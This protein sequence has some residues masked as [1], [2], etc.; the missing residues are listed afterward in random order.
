MSHSHECDTFFIGMRHIFYRNATPYL[1]EKHYFCTM[2]NIF[3]TLTADREFSLILGSAVILLGILFA[4][5]AIREYKMY[6]EDNYKARPSLADFFKQEQFYLYLWLVFLF[7][8]S[9]IRFFA[10]LN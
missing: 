7:M 2:E 6:L 1:L 8:V 10:W 3:T 4:C 9:L 5:V